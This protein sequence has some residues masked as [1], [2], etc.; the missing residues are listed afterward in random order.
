MNVMA[1]KLGQ[2]T[3]FLSPAD[4]ASGS[5][6]FLHLHGGSFVQEPTWQIPRP[7]VRLACR[8]PELFL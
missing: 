8:F 6:R 3:N 2:G 5:A 7:G 4:C 1:I